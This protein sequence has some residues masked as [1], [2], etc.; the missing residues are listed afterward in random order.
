MTTV[1]HFYD[2]Y[3]PLR[4]PGIQRQFLRILLR[5]EA[6]NACAAYII[7]LL[8]TVQIQRRGTNTDRSKFTLCTLTLCKGSVLY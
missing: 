5:S 1:L 2:I 4:T 8:N 6:Q 7:T 3:V